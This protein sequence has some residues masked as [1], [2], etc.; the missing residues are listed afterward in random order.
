MNSKQQIKSN[1]LYSNCNTSINNP[2]EKIYIKSKSTHTKFEIPF[3]LSLS[4]EIIET[5]IELENIKNVFIYDWDDTFLC[6]SYFKKN[7]IFTDNFLLTTNDKEHLS[8]LEKTV[9]KLLNLSIE[10]GTVYI[11]TNS[12]NGWVE[13]STKKFYPLLTPLLDKVIIKSARSLY[14]KKYPGK[15]KKW[16]IQSFLDLQEELNNGFNNMICFGDSEEEIEASCL[17]ASKLKNCIN[18][19]VK[20]KADPKIEDLNRQLSIILDRF[21]YILKSKKNLTIEVEKE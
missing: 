15:M 1:K 18:K 12:G 21:M 4:K 2:N 8:S 7:D 16:K 9:Y 6:T 5:K 3:K 19:T 13:W 11:I 14:E 17:L 20:L 10:N